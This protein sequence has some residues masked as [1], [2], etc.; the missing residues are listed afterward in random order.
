M[1]SLDIPK[2]DE[3]WHRLFLHKLSSYKISVRV[4][5][6]INYF[7]PG[8]SIKLVYHRPGTPQQ[9]KY[10]LSDKQYGFRF[11][12]S[13]ADVLTEILDNEIYMFSMTALDK[14]ARYGISG[15]DLS[16]INSFL[17]WRSRF[18]ANPQR[19]LRSMLASH[20][21][22]SSVLLSFYFLSTICPRTKVYGCASKYMDGHCRLGDDLSSGL[23]SQLNGWYNAIHPKVNS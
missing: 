18:M 6:V 21:V 15:R 16:V 23:L 5:A 8:G 19:H 17:S 2:N 4:L 20:K 10:L 3:I 22:L 12:R 14:H 13:P 11:S 9:K 1:I 7:L